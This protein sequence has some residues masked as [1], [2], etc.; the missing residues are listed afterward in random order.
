MV[1]FY[2]KIYHCFQIIT[3]PLKLITL[4]TA[5][6]HMWGPDSFVSSCE[7]AKITKST[8]TTNVAN[9]VD[10]FYSKVYYYFQ[11][12][13]R[14]LKLITLTKPS[15]HM[16]SKDPFVNSC[17][18]AKITKSTTTTNVANLLNLLYSNIYHYFQIVL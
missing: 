5:S 8:T 6:F 10:L 2:S 14:P 15:F 11:I 18:V 3:K 13:R 16:W 7:V 17:E 12:I 4:T 1:L 9:L